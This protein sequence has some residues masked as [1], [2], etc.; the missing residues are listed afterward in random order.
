MGIKFYSRKPVR[1]V[2]NKRCSLV[3]VAEEQKMI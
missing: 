1:G 2:N 3:L